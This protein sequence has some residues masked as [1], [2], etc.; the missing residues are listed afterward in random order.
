MLEPEGFSHALGRSLV[1]EE[2]NVLQDRV[3]SHLKEQ[4]GVEIR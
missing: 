3:V 4:L 2:V 1:N